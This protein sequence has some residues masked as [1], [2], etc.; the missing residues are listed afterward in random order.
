MVLGHYMGTWEVGHVA[1]S[2]GELRLKG[3]GKRRGGLALLGITILLHFL[4][5]L[6]GVLDG[7]AR[8]IY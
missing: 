6:V 8:G 3:E 2:R 1:L 5:Y 4:P 7:E